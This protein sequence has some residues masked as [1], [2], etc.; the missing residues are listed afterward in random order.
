[1]FDDL[2]YKWRGLNLTGRKKKKQVTWNNRD[3]SIHGHCTNTHQSCKMPFF[4]PITKLNVPHTVDCICVDVHACVHHRCLEAEHATHA[5]MSLHARLV[6]KEAAHKYDNILLKE[7]YALP[8][9][10]SVG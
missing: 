5:I 3:L 10:V 1:M 6:Q 7:E 4:Q 2:E 8:A 9:V